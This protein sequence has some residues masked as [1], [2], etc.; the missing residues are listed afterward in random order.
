MRCLNCGLMK[1]G[2]RVL[3]R[4]GKMAGRVWPDVGEER[5]TERGRGNFQREKIKQ[6]IQ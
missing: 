6:I 3:E 2:W 5:R 4:S 1:L